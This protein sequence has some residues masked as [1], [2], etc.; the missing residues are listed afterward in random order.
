MRV[1]SGSLWPGPV[2]ALRWDVSREPFLRLLV[3]VS[4]A[5]GAPEMAVEVSGEEYEWMG[6]RFRQMRMKKGVDGADVE[7]VT[8][9]SRA[10]S[11]SRAEMRASW[12]LCIE[13]RLLLRV[14]ICCWMRWKRL[15]MSWM[16][17]LG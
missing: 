11:A 3:L 15:S 9:R 6:Y 13:S 5:V 10:I 1:S 14:L 12:D 16:E 2:E 8:R 17:G 7:G 4:P